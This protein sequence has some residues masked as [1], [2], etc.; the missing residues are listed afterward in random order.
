[1]D[2]MRLVASRRHRFDDHR[3]VFSSVTSTSL[4]LNK[5]DWIACVSPTGLIPLTRSMD[6]IQSPYGRRC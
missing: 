4:G 1:M 2:Q 6:F 3:N 5:L